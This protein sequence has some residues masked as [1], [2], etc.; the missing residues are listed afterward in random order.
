MRPCLVVIPKAFVLSGSWCFS[1]EPCSSVWC[2]RPHFPL[3]RAVMQ[4]N[5]DLHCEEMLFL[6][7]A[8]TLR[9]VYTSLVS[10]IAYDKLQ[11]CRIF[12]PHPAVSNPI[13]RRLL[14]SP[15][16]R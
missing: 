9:R 14:N 11:P 4:V 15:R 8:V 3:G 10:L 16:W 2:L 13:I 12:I 6:G 1:S 5:L 7:V